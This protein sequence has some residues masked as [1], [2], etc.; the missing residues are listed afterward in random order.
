MLGFEVT[1]CGFEEM[2]ND[3]PAFPIQQISTNM[4]FKDNIGQ[5]QLRLRK[6]LCGLSKGIMMQHDVM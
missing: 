1:S 3:K 2:I 4:M 6:K 5:D